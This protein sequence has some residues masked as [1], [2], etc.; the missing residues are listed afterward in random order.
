VRVIEKVTVGKRGDGS[1]IRVEVSPIGS[2]SS[3]FEASSMRCRQGRRTRS[4]P[5]D[6]T[7]R[8]S[9]SSRRP[10]RS[11]A[12]HDS[13]TSA[14]P[15][16][17]SPVHELHCLTY[18]RRQAGGAQAV[19]YGRPVPTAPPVTPR[20]PAG[21]RVPHRGTGAGRTQPARTRSRR[22]SSCSRSLEAMARDLR[23]PGRNLGE[24]TKGLGCG[25]PEAIVF[26]GGGGWI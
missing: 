2:P 11:R 5:S 18:M 14:A 9:T 23:D 12:V 25:V 7:A 17:F 22:R 8:S 15:I 4:W 19:G 20:K 26:D 1:L 21:S 10:P 13:A 16:G 3:A 24:D 6:S